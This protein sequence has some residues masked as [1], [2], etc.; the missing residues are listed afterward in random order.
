MSGSSTSWFC[1]LLL[2]LL[3]SSSASLTSGELLQEQVGDNIS[4]CLFITAILLFYLFQ[5][6]KATDADKNGPRIACHLE[7]TLFSSRATCSGFRCRCSQ[8]CTVLLTVSG[9]DI[10]TAIVLFEQRTLH[11]NTWHVQ[12]QQ[13]LLVYGINSLFKLTLFP[14]KRWFCTKRWP[15]VSRHTAFSGLK[16][17]L[18]HVSP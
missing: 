6:L 18:L 8:H 9:W 4:N 13:A 14:L 15:K 12:I 10:Y 11:V 3:V 16:K 17:C 7:G 1:K 2:L 5:A